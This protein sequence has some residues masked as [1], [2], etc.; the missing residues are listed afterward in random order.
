MNSIFLNTLGAFQ[1][2]LHTSR[3]VFNVE[4]AQAYPLPMPVTIRN[5]LQC[6]FGKRLL[7]WVVEIPASIG[8]LTNLI[9]TN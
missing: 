2:A 1:L 8:R 9:M 3:I 5:G 7:Q 6:Y 4:W